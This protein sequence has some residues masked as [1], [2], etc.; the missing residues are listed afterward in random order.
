M[1]DLTERA[2]RLDA[3]LDRSGLEAVWFGTP[4]SFAWVVGG[5]NRVDRTAS[6]GEAA[7][8]YTAGGNWH[9]V[10]NNIEADRLAAEELPPEFA[11][12]VRTYDW[13]EGDLAGAVAA[14]TPEPAAADFDAPGLDRVDPMPLR[15]RLSDSDI[16]RYR[17]LGREAAAAVE[18]VCQELE[19]DDTESEV[20]AGLRIALAARGIDAPVVLV[21][22]A[23]RAR[24]YRHFTP[25][26]TELGEYALLS[27]TAVRDGL[28]ASLTRTVVFDAPD[29]F[30]DRYEAAVEVDAHIIAATYEAATAGG[31]VSDDPLSDAG[32]TSG[33]VFEELLDAYA[34]VGWPEEWRSHHQGGATGYAGREWFAVPDGDAP[35]VPSAAYAWNPTVRGT[36]SEDTVLVSAE[37][38]EVLTRTGDWP[39]REFEVGDLTLARPDPLDF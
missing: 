29:W 22:G 7:V 6:V 24:Q 3:Y 17:A 28:H 9:I 34:E 13:H 12:S 39:T 35:V 14:F 38:V 8:G 4:A 15:L 37:G 20:A 27:V 30:N 21:G 11:A 26:G 10:T 18:T 5:D 25:T 16:D 1:V 33:A 36:K 32:T 2:E 31:P 23:E 19:P